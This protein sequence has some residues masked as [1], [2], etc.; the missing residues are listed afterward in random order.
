[1]TRITWCA[2]NTSPCV[3]R[4]L[5][6]IDVPTVEI[7]R[8]ACKDVLLVERFDRVGR[9][10]RWLRKAMVSALTMQGLDDTNWARATQAIR[11]LPKSCA[12]VLQIRQAI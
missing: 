7:A 8:I 9:G 2:G 1:M 6:H 12:I 4:E 10:D 5:S 11:P 3:W